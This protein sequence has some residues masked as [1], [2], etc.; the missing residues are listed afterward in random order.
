VDLQSDRTHCG[1]C[2][3]ACGQPAP[4]CAAGTCTC[5][6]PR[7]ACAA[8]CTD[9]RSDAS[10]CGACGTVCPLTNDVCVGGTC[11]CPDAL[12]DAC[13]EAGSP[14]TCVSLAHDVKNC[15]T[16]G[17]A[18]AAG[19][20]CVDGACACP[21]GKTVCGTG[22]AAICTDVLSDPANCGT[23]GT[24]CAPG[25]ACS[26]GRCLCPAD[27]PWACG[28]GCCAGTGCCEGG[29]ACQTAHDNGL[30]QT[31]Y[32][33]GVLDEHTQAQAL[34]AAFAWSATGATHDGDTVCGTFCLCQESGTQAAVW[35]YAGSPMKGLATVSNVGSCAVATCPFAGGVAW[36]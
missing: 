7:T 33:C 11:Q 18:C 12:P 20:D 36:H 15:G 14:Q 32:D 22:S 23:C 19:Q 31:Y 13:P 29:T 3:V 16:C 28:G 34:L 1:A 26:G 2:D 24:A 21:P 8:A 35:C 27:A 17:H 4:D 30:G 5:N 9:T 25:T 10:N 6:P